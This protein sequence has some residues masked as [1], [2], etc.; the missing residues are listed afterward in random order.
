MDTKQRHLVNKYLDLFSR[1]IVL[2]SVI[3]LL[4]LPAG[5]LAYLLTPKVYQASA[6]L[7]YQQQSIGTSQISPEIVNKIRDII[8]TL[9]QIVTSRTNLEKLIVDL[10]LYRDARQRL[11]MEDVVESMRKKISMEPSSKGD[12][13]RISFT[14][15]DP[16]KV[17]RVTNALA[18]KFIEENLK[19][20]EERATET[21]EYTQDELSKAKE[22][23]DRKEAI[24]RDYKVKYYNEMPEQRMT[25]VSRLISLTEQLQGKQESIQD[26]E[27]TLVMILDQIN[28]RKKVLAGSQEPDADQLSQNSGSLAS[29][30]LS[31][32]QQLTRM[33]RALEQLMTRYT[34]KHPEVRRVKGVIARIEEEIRNNGGDPNLDEEAGTGGSTEPADPFASD[35]MILQLETQRK[36]ILLSIENIKMEMVQLR[37]TVKEYE[38]W[39]TAAPTREAEWSSLTREYGQLKRHYEY[40]VAQDLEARSMLNLERKQKG[41]QFRIEDPGRY[42]EKPIKPNFMIIMGA[43]LMLGLGGALG[44]TLAM[45]FFDSSFRD[46]ET[47]EQALGI[48]LLTA[49]PYA[50]TAQEKKQASKKRWLIVVLLGIGFLLVA[51]LFFVVWRK[52]YI[53][54]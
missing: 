50:E 15:G 31:S 32:R 36:N 43:G 17:V 19:Y 41:S 2:I 46:P 27:R 49:I 8:N 11:P 52:G 33:R 16:N 34:D 13:F 20:R 25:N 42:P 7:S 26:L 47:I 4:S 54:I 35:R 29:T 44:L 39:V 23:M 21:S 53:I 30:S 6:L 45:D 14:H 28:N 3:L 37:A 10:D 38:E 9:T 5:L 1:R 12:I 22:M 40:L 51:A 24:M 48:P 18:A